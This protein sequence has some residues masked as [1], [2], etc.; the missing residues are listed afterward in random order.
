M[1]RGGYG[2]FY[3]GEDFRGSGGNLVMNP[4]N[5]LSPVVNPVGTAQP[6]YLLSDPV[7]AFLVTSVEPGRLRAHRAA[8]AR[9]EPGRC[10]H[11]AMERGGRAAPAAPVDH[12]GRLRREPGPQPARYSPGQSD[13][14]RLGRQRGGQSAVPDVE[15]IGLYDTKA[16]SQ[17]NGLQTK[18]EHRFT[19][20]WYNLTSYTYRAGLLRDGWL[21]SGQCSA[22]LRRLAVGIPPRQPDAHATACRS[23]TSTSCRLDAAV[24]SERT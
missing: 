5:M 15:H 11:P 6:P 3:G 12:R 9:P 7:P 19:K 20:G 18:Y 8:G 1:V 22:A 16:R 24:R 10:Y 21:R 2:L 13:A 4:P 14:V 23:P 17:Y